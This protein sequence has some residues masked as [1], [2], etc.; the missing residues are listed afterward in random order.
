M[1]EILDTLA[2][3]PQIIAAVLAII[4]NIGG[5]LAQLLK[6]KQLEP[7][8]VTKLAETLVMFEAVFLILSTV[9]G[10]P[11]QYVAVAAIAVVVIR[12][13]KSALTNTVAK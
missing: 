6:I 5:Y 2:N 4:W 9:A 8:E 1:V 7:Y 3:N 10:V 13:L 11:M 12:S